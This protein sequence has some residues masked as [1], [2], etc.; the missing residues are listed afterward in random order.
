MHGNVTNVFAA[1]AGVQQHAQPSA[2]LSFDMIHLSG[3]R[4]MIR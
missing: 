1:L 2:L 3:W 4:M